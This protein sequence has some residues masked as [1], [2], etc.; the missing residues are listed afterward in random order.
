MSKLK[1]FIFSLILIFCI[2]LLAEGIARLFYRPNEY[3][4]AIRERYVTKEEDYIIRHKRL[5]WIFK[6]GYDGFPKVFDEIGK[7][8]RYTINNQGLRD[9][10]YPFVKSEDT[11]RLFCSG[12]SIT[13]GTGADNDDAYPKALERYL[14]PQQG[15]LKY[16]VI[17]G[18]IGDYNT[19]QEYLLLK[20][21][22][23]K[24]YPDIVILQLYPNDGRVYV[25]PKSLFLEEGLDA[26]HAKSAFVYFLDRGI[27]RL[28]IA[29]LKKQWEK[30]RARWQPRYYEYKW[31]TDSAEVDTLI[32]LGDKDCG[33]LWREIGLKEVKKQLDK[34]LFLSQEKKFKLVVVYF[35][36]TFQ[37]HGAGSAR[38][39][40]M[41]PNKDMQKYCEDN[42]IPFMSLI[43]PLKED[44]KKNSLN[45]IFVDYC[46]YTAK[47]A[48]IV[49]EHIGRF[50]I[51]EGIIGRR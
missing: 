4:K 20:E 27:R 36:V 46:H 3:K 33:A 13:M 29:I 35:P 30:G 32:D 17:N 34:I 22:G 5:G 14:N 50:L 21:I 48:E 12:D 44:L 10:D 38:H 1:Q 24:Y 26:F 25:P 19:F 51:D 18:G 15:N 47:G 31:L 6:P 45:E 41:K 42:N 9:K 8:E 39:D 40:L 2:F 11:I 37:L 16:E 43:H 23:I 49:A 7:P 28:M